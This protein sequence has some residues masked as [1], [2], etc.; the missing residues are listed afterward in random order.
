MKK[1]DI[2]E[3]LS[4]SFSIPKK[5]A[6]EIVNIFFDSITEA[7]VK[8]EEVQLRGL[9][10]FKIRQRRERIGRNPKTGEKVKIPSKK[11]VYFKQGKEIQNSL[12]RL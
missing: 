1:N 11:V 3:H 12:K 6:V 8:G 4:N 9:G 5:L 2:A 7:L 10:T